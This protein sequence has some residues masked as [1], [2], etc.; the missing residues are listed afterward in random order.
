M[1]MMKMI[2]HIITMTT[3]I[4]RMIKRHKNDKT[5]QEKW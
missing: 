4:I 3:M 1:E 2:P 5:R